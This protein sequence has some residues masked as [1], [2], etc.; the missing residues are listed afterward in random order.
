MELMNLLPPIYEGNKTMRELQGILTADVN[1]LAANLNETVDECFVETATAL[2]SRYEKLYGLSV[3]VTK[4][5]TFRRERIK[6][7]IR[8][9]G[10]VTRQMIIDT[11]ASYS[12]GQVE[13]IENPD[14][15]SFIIKFVG[16][17]GIPANMRDLTITMEEI[18]PAHLSYTFEYVYNTWKDISG[19]TWSEAAAY[20]WEELR[21][22]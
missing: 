12:N 5:D 18:K 7:K 17:K 11:A 8:G 14:S 20:T 19:M 1:N 13:V 4:S 21:M 6:A 10:T 15:C 16:T 9:V 3:D 22:R 2:L